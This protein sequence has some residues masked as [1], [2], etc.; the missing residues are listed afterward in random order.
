VKEFSISF[1][2]ETLGLSLISPERPSV[3]NPALVGII[4]KP[5]L[6]PGLYSGDAITKING[7]SVSG[8]TFNGV[9][10]RIKALPRPII[11]HFVQVIA[12]RPS[13]EYHDHASNAELKESDSTGLREDI[14]QPNVNDED[15]DPSLITVPLH[16]GN[17]SEVKLDPLSPNH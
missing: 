1:R 2:V 17:D 3:D 12:A 7:L 8:M 5:D 6:C 9:V 4:H 13:K 15:D 14:R 11:I 10:S 16:T